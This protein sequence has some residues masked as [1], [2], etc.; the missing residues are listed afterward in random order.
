MEVLQKTD[1]RVALTQNPQKIEQTQEILDWPSLRPVSWFSWFYALMVTV[2]LQ[3]GVRMVARAAHRERGRPSSLLIE[4]S[5]GLSIVKQGR[6]S[7]TA[8]KVAVAF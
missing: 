3:C 2:W 7:Q 8:L 5:S 1:Q 4:E 6:I